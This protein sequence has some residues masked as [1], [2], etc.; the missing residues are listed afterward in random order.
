LLINIFLQ[1]I[2][3]VGEGKWTAVCLESTSVTKA[4]HRITVETIKPILDLCD[5]VHHLQN[6]IKDINSVAIFKKVC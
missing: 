1:A 3:S 4:G 2:L 5:A 6:T